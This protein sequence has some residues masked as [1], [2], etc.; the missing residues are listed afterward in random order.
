[1]NLLYLLVSLYVN[2]TVL[3]LKSLR[4]GNIASS[5]FNTFW[6]QNY[7]MVGYLEK[8]HPPDLDISHEALE[9]KEESRCHNSSWCFGH[10]V[11]LTE[12]RE[13][14]P[15]GSPNSKAPIWSCRIECQMDSSKSSSDSW[16][17]PSL[18]LHIQMLLVHWCSLFLNF[19]HHS[20]DQRHWKCSLHGGPGRLIKVT[21]KLRLVFQP[22]SVVSKVLGEAWYQDWFG[23]ISPLWQ[24]LET[25]I[26]HFHTFFDSNPFVIPPVGQKVARR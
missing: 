14:S 23:L 8:I 15:A 4:S 2:P 1:M 6:E 16:F 12:D 9:A 24:K 19:G 21:R 25:K 7:L 20:W 26:S 11:G 10:R 13:T 5:I 22:S 3:S 18:T 17:L